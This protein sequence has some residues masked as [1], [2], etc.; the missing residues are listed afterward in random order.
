MNYTNN[1]GEYTKVSTEHL[2]TALRIKIELQNASPSQRCAWKKHRQLMEQEG[3]FDSDTSENYRC[4]IKAYQKSLGKLPQLKK[5]V[6]MIATKKLESISSF[7]GEI[8]E[9][10]RDNQN[11]LREL[12]KIKRQ[13]IDGNLYTKTMVEGLRNSME[14]IE[15]ERL[16]SSDVKDKIIIEN[17]DTAIALVSDWH[18]GAL[19]KLDGKNEYNYEIAKRRVREYT[20]ELI[21]YCN[22]HNIQKIEVVFMG[23]AIEGTYMRAGQGFEAE[24]GTSEQ[25]AKFSTLI[26]HM[27]NTL[28]KAHSVRYR[29]FAGNHDRMNQMDKGNNVHGDSAIYLSNEIVKT[30]IENVD[31]PN[32]EYVTTDH[33]SATLEVNGFNIKLVHGD[34]EK[35]NDNKKIHE[36]SSRDGINYNI[37]A[38]G[39][40]HH[41]LVLEVGLERFELRVGSTKGID[42]YAEK[43]GLGSSPSQVI[44]GINSEGKL[45]DIKRVGLV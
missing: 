2:D 17:G 40:F 12:N 10:K 41:F 26:I 44:I 1:D 37:I 38:Y 23:D 28:S 9:E 15:W 20:I 24:F 19:V 25:I 14:D 35:K 29:A 13:I 31:N 34:L 39:H 6:E 32:I 42:H 45:M 16:I 27:L 30:F 43:F 7:V 8:A 11:V 21:K 3:F 18:I 36:H 5:H 22:V 4:M 33:Y